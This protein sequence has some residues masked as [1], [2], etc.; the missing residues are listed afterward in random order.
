VI[1]LNNREFEATV[2]CDHLATAA[3]VWQVRNRPESAIFT[4]PTPGQ[5]QT[6]TQFMSPAAILGPRTVVLRAAYKF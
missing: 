3:T 5:R 4:D 2:D 1:K 6:L